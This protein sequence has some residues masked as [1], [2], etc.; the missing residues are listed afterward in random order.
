MALCAFMAASDITAQAAGAIA[1]GKCDRNGYSYGVGSPAGAARRAI[2]ECM[3]NGDATCHV[4]VT[5]NGVCGAFA[6]AGPGGCSARGWAYAGSRGAAEN[7]ALAN[8]LKYGGGNC[9]I[10]AWVCDR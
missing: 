4:V 5:L 3:S 9:R 8:C 6:V 1:I 2:A 7:I 10:Q